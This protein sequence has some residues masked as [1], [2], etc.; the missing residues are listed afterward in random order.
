MLTFALQ[1]NLTLNDGPSSTANGIPQGQPPPYVSRPTRSENRP[2]R[3]M[4]GASG[5]FPSRSNEDP[6]RRLHTGKPQ[7]NELDVFA[8]P[9]SPE[10]GQR[11]PRPRRNSDSSINSRIL[12]P[13]DER[14]R[15]ERHRRER[16][17]RHRGD[18]KSRPLT[19]SKSKKPNKQVDIIDSLDVTSMFGTGGKSNNL[20]SRLFA[21]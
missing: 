3:P 2:P 21:S 5:H 6:D 18:G 12:S 14:R 9:A 15:K 4:N 11:R 8:D 19:S 16:E 1:D 10:N 13:D 17:A 7:R 20:A